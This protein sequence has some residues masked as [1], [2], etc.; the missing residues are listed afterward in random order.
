MSFA[1]CKGGG[2]MKTL[3]EVIFGLSYN[4]FYNNFTADIALKPEFAFVVVYG[5]DA[6]KDSKDA[7]RKRF[8]D[9]GIP[10]E[11]IE[12]DDGLVECAKIIKSRNT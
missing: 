3:N 7:L 5:I 9:A 10:K 8:V 2:I 4:T 6:P 11:L 1:K 12:E